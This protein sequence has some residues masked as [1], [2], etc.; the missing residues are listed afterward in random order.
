MPFFDFNDC[1]FFFSTIFGGLFTSWV[2]SASWRRL[3]E[4]R[5][6]ARNDVKSFRFYVN[7]RNG[8]EKGLCI[9]MLGALE[10][11]FQVGTFYDFSGIHDYN[12]ITEFTHNAEIMPD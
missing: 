9:R 11:R 6:I 5:H 4:L 7:S 12:P 8:F 10:N 3:N 1:R 2:E